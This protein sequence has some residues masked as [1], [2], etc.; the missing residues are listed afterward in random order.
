MEIMLNYVLLL[1]KH[2]KNNFEVPLDN[3]VFID[4]QCM[5]KSIFPMSNSTNNNGPFSGKEKASTPVGKTS[6][7]GGFRNSILNPDITTKIAQQIGLTFVSEKEAEGNVCMANSGEVRAEFRENFSTIDVLDYI[8]GVMHSVSDQE[9]NKESLKLD[10]M[11]IPLPTDLSTFQKFTNLGSKIRQTPS[12]Q[13]P[14]N[15]IYFTEF[16]LEGEYIVAKS[17]YENSPPPEGCPQDGV[18]KKVFQPQIYINS[19]QIILNPIL[20]LPYNPKLKQRVRELRQAE[21]LSEVLFW[22]QVTKGGFHKIDFDRQRVIGNFI[23]D[24][25]VKKLGLVIEIDGSSHDCKQEYD[26]KREAYLVSLGLR[27]YKIKVSAIMNKMNN[28][29]KNLENYI[30]QNYGVK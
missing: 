17:S 3:P 25:Y 23:V 10:S 22:M 2:L 5:P 19:T 11:R 26:A 24:F 28:V 20:E 13:T 29:I 6:K 12:L 9:N 1:L 15:K 21:N 7:G 4:F 27:V 8:F 30:I 16:T 14:K 18:V